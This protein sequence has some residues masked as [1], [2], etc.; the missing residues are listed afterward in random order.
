MQ[1][2]KNQV[3]EA[4][5]PD[6]RVNS[7]EFFSFRKKIGDNEVPPLPNHFLKMVG[8]PFLNFFILTEKQKFS[9]EL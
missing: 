6:T 8:N 4:P 2:I 5:K 7:E 9:F 3:F 1:K